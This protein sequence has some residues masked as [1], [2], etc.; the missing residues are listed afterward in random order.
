MSGAVLA[1]CCMAAALAVPTASPAAARTARLVRAGRLGARHRRP[2]RTFGGLR[3]LRIGRSGSEAARLTE[4]RRATALLAAEL[5]AGSRPA[6]AVHAAADA[7][8]AA[9]D[10]FLA[11]VRD[12]GRDGAGLD[13]RFASIARAWAVAHGTGAPL[14]DVLRRVS[15]DLAAQ[16]EQLRR[17]DAAL[18]GPRASALVLSL[19]PA[20]GLALGATLGVHPVA[21]LVGTPAG[22]IAGTCGV[23][24]HAAGL[25]WTRR[26]LRHA[27]R[28]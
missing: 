23:L 10:Q 15:A 14:A 5:D 8:P 11:L 20:L 4:L 18:A 22:R 13:R 16:V 24:L 6:A 25:L 19:L 21:V 26:I 2:A 17:V 27:R 3:R 7:C 12:D 28:A 9:A 1:W